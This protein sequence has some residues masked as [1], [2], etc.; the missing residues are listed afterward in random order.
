MS[1][2]TSSPPPF[3]LPYRATHVNGIALR[4]LDAGAGPAVLLLHGFPDFAYTWRHQLQ[5]LADAGYRVIAPDLRGGGGSSRPQDT[6][7]YTYFH[8]IG[9]LIALMDELG[10]GEAV[11]VGHDMGAYVAWNMSLIIPERVRAVAALSIALRRRPPRPPLELLGSVY[12]PRF[13]QIQFQT[14]ETPEADLDARVE[15]FLPGILVGLSADAAEPVTSL[16]LPEGAMFSDLFPAPE[17]LPRWLTDQDVAAYVETFRATGFRGEL[18]AYRNI[19]RNWEL[20]A[21]WAH[22]R[23]SV[24]AMYV[25]GDLD[26]AYI[27]AK[28]SGSLQEMSSMVPDLR[29]S[30]V[31]PHTGHW[32]SQERPDELN[33]E[34][35]TFLNDL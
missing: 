27:I 29:R 15:T 17:R 26:I 4:Y 16:V 14:L 32:I 22:A 5:P 33:A 12:G 18:A 34:L 25:T 23:V 21:P 7:A 30:T 2:D 3:G 11:V 35:L 31:L 6:H 28:Q 1:V 13:Y 20:M 24:P 10:V 8:V 19:D 9:D